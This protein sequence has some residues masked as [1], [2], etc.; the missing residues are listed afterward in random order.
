MLRVRH[1]INAPDLGMIAW[2]GGVVPLAVELGKFEFDGSHLGV[3]YDTPLGYW[4]V[5]SSLCTVRRFWWW[6]P[7]QFRR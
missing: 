5:S 2:Q 6:W 7:S 1:K 4:P 3:G